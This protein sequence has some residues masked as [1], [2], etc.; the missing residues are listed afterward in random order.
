MDKKPNRAAQAEDL[1]LDVKIKAHASTEVE[2]VL[3]SSEGIPSSLQLFPYMR[4]T[5]KKGGFKSLDFCKFVPDK[6]SAY[7]I[8]SA[9]FL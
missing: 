7:L 8:I 6:M 9:T 4:N 3:W 5:V 1:P 2:G